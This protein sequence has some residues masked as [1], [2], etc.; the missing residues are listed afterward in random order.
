MR[1]NLEMAKNNI[2]RIPNLT[3]LKSH[4]IEDDCI[5]N[6]NVTKVDLTVPKRMVLITN[7]LGMTV[8]MRFVG[9][10][11]HNRTRSTADA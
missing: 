4:S 10:S 7:A 1:I 6:Y 11:L 8:L 2:G 9:A 3:G 5:Q